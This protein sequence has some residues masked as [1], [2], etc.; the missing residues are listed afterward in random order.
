M[1]TDTARHILQVFAGYFSNGSSSLPQ[2]LTAG[3]DGAVAVLHHCIDS[4]LDER[5]DL[6][7][8][9]GEMFLSTS[10]GAVVP[11]W[12]N[13]NGSDLHTLTNVG[14]PVSHVENVKT[15]IIE[16]H[17][18]CGANAAMYDALLNNADANGTFEGRWMLPV[19]ADGLK[20]AL[21]TAK[22]NG[23]EDATLLR[24]VEQATVLQS[25][26]NLF[27]YYFNDQSVRD[28]VD[29]GQLRI[30]GAVR[31]LGRDESGKQAL[32]VFDPDESRFRDLEEIHAEFNSKQI[33]VGP[34]KIT[35]EDPPRNLVMQQGAR[36]QTVAELSTLQ[37]D[38]ALKRLVNTIAQTTGQHNGRGA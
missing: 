20:E 18:H 36:S 1:R 31:D 3:Q 32:Y 19:A 5:G 23:A 9:K 8:G 15:I 30:V 12:Q 35:L 13:G 14:Y 25:M 24:M 7:I 28:F 27:D 4:R 38:N 34:A 26:R 29:S 37:L 6:D 21:Q 22:A 10:A 11:P 33:I 17:T 2:D 16:G